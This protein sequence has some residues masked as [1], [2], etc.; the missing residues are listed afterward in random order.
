MMSQQQTPEPVKKTPKKKKAEF[1]RKYHESYLKSRFNTSNVN[2]GKNHHTPRPYSQPLLCENTT[3][4]VTGL[5][6][7]K[8]WDHCPTPHNA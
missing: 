4:H 3:T 7:K 6:C 2:F 8:W 1:S 5:C